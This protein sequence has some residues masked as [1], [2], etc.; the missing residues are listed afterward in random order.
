MV[1]G[2]RFGAHQPWEHIRDDNIVYV[3]WFS[4]GLRAVDISNPYQPRE[5]ARYVPSDTAREFVAQSNDVFVDNRGI[6]Y[7]IDRYRGLSVLE[8]RR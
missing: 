4:G 2:R 6:V 8:F 1:P 7:L 5:I 3:T